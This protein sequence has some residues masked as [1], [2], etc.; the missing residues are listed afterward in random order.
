[1]PVYDEKYIES[2]VRELN[3]A[4]KI[5]VLGNKIPKK[6]ALHLHCLYK[7]TFCYENRNENYPEVYLEQCKH[8][9]KKIKM[10]K[11]RETELE[12]ESESELEFGI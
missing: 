10:T 7:Y 8:R 2:K 6:H 5:N 4:I 9:I 3:G 1:M 12:S 11:F